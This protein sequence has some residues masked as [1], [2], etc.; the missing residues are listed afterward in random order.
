MATIA[1]VREKYPQYSDMPDA[2][3]ADALHKKFYSDMPR[4]D[5]DTKIG[6]TTMPVADAK[7]SRKDLVRQELL[8]I[9]APFVGAAKGA[10]DIVLGAQRLVGKGLQA[11]GADETGKALIDDALRRKAQ[12]E[13]DIAEYEQ[14]S[15][16][17]TSAGQLA[18]EIAAT[19]PV[20]GVIAK[21]VSKIPGAGQFAEAIRTGGF[22]TGASAPTTLG[23]RVADVATRAT[24]GGIVGGTSAALVNPDETFTGATI[25]AV[26]PLVLPTVGKYIAIGGGKIVDASSGKL[27][28]VEAGK[29][30]REAAG[31]QINQI[32]AINNLAPIDLTAS[33]AAY[34]IENDVYQAFLAFV[35]GKDKSSYF[36]ILKD[37][38]KTD[39]LNQLAK[40]A[41]GGNLT[42][43][44]E[45]IK[46]SKN[47]LNQ[48]MT[49]ILKAELNAANAAGTTGV[50]LQAE[51][52]RFAS[53]AT[54]KVQDVRRFVAAGE[55]A[56]DR[57]NAT[58]PVAGIPRAAG[59]YTY[60]GELADK[61]DEV[62]T[63]AASGSLIFGEAARFSQAAAD[64]LTAYGLKPLTSASILGR[65]GGILRNPAFAGND[66][67]EGA[68]KSFGD[69]VAKWTNNGG[70]IDGF[71]LDS[72]RKNSVNAAI[73]KL[74]P[75]LDQTSK[76]NLASK[77]I[78]QLKKPIVDAIEE[79]GG[80]GYGQYLADYA[81]NAQL[82][83]RAKL[84]GQAKQMFEKSPKEF[85]RLIQGN[86][87][88]AVEAIFGAGSFNIFKEMGSD[89]KPMQKIV[90]QLVRDEKL[91]EQAS[92]GAKTLSELKEL[93]KPS[94]AS[95]FPGFVGTTTA[96][97]KKVTQTLEGKVSDRTVAVLANAA[98]T[99]K[100]MNEI[101]N[102]LPANEQ[103]IVLKLLK[104]SA[105]AKRAA[106]ATTT[107]TFT[108][109][110]KNALSPRSQ[111]QNALAQQ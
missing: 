41:G 96:V 47:A 61:A 20:G 2:A 5:F 109:E 4:A 78:G 8:K 25:G 101:L 72:L 84:A 31:D 52:D 39:Q 100:N 6:L 3:L 71:A 14:A 10:G 54:D 21:G 69:D 104:N 49:P 85:E 86:N 18:G 34:G 73:E 70:V 64:S 77:V 24:G 82:I 15:P 76:N 35:S 75:G 40:L 65:L 58:Y 83:N 62:A 45:T 88:D 27:A 42:E 91:A 1:E 9:N 99:G 110:S 87:P 32:R 111:N 51:A 13:K 7:A 80:T 102:T 48:V 43:S 81:A 11:I 29:I 26:A 68:V 55:R 103:S 66:V 22:R 60:M 92:A 36:R 38:T 19:L 16:T 23:G 30:A 59:R 44:L 79:A 37:Q 57:A 53:A 105:E 67:I 98:K 94:F 28:N 89:I 46:Q 106:T 12:A 107:Q 93:N 97:A 56:T 90:S 50:R 33:Q 95:F 108:P 74:R 17:F 63:Q